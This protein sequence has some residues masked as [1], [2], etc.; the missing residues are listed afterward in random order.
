LQP[1]LYCPATAIFNLEVHIS[2]A[3]AL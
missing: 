3:M 1:Q 2:A